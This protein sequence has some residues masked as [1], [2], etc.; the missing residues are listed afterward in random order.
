MPEAL[1]SHPEPYRHAF[2]TGS[3]WTGWGLPPKNY[4][5]WAQLIY[6]W[7]RHCTER[8]GAREV[9]SWYWEVWNEPDIGYWQG[10]PEEYYKLYDFAADAVKARPAHG[11]DR[12]TAQHG[13]G[14]SPSGQFSARF[15]EH[16]LHGKNF[17]TGKIGSPLDHIGFHAK[18][19]PRWS[20]GPRSR[21]AFATKPK[22]FERL[23]NR[24]D[25]SPS[26]RQ[27]GYYRRVRSGGLR[28]VL[29]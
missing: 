25:F 1:S 23:R 6:Q 13:A 20:G 22:Y 2:P 10:T 5:A 15:F 18:G 14:G 27:T 19:N 29:G 28:R 3:L 9:E 21:W 11:K 17:A 4:R 26:A 16:A 24:C 8:Y 7:V 12:R